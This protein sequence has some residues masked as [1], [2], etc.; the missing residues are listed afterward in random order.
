VSHTVFVR[1]SS[2]SQESLLTTISAWIAWFPVLFY[3]T[4][5]IGDLYKRVAPVPATDEEQLLLDAEATR[6]GSRALLYSSL[7]SLLVNITLPIFVSESSTPSVLQNKES[8]WDR[9]CR[10]P[11]WLQIDLATLWAISHFVFAACML[12]TL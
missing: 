10:V 5:Y 2:T 8:W 12:A 6:L 7:L 9:V 1:L 4:I 3:S 11:N